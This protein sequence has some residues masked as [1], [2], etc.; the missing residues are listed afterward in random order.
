MKTSIANHYDYVTNI[1]P[2]ILGKHFHYGFYKDKSISLDNATDNLVLE[3]SSLHE[4]GI[5]SKILDVGC[6]IGQPAIIL[7]SNYNCKI[8]GI[9]N[10]LSGVEI[11]N[12][13]IKDLGKEKEIIF[14]F[15]DSINNKLPDN[16][17]DLAWIMEVTHLIKEKEGALL[18]VS[19]KLKTKGFLLLSDLCITLK[20]T[21][22]EIFEYKNEIEVLHQTFGYSIIKSI[23]F[24]K[25]TIY[26][27]GH[28][29][30]TIKDISENVNPTIEAW[31]TNA[32]KNKDQ[33]IKISN[34][35]YYS[36]LLQSFDIL[37][38]FFKNNYLGYFL[39]YSQKNENAI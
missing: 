19:K 12:K 37:N 29:I 11:A 23:D 1:W 13:H 32:I 39:L 34:D 36:L 38:F 20:F 17:F 10:S 35:H 33:I 15:G 4:F 6:G 31:R 7:H 25:E 2:F 5:D 8:W 28:S 16:F 3:L 18:A 30:K 9:S 22:K 26:H 27:I 14:E 24:Y 21:L